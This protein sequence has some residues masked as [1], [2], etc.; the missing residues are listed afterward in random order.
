MF[1]LKKLTKCLTYKLQRTQLKEPKL[2]IQRHRSNGLL[3]STNTHYTFQKNFGRWKNIGP[4]VQRSGFQAPMVQVYLLPNPL[5]P[6]TFILATL[7]ILQVKTPAYPNVY[8]VHVSYYYYHDSLKASCYLTSESSHLLLPFSWPTL[9]LQFCL[10]RS[11]PAEELL[12]TYPVHTGTQYHKCT[13][14]F[15]CLSNQTVSCLRVKNMSYLCIPKMPAHGKETKAT[16]RKNKRMCASTKANDLWSG[17][18]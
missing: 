5:F 1:C 7:N 6:C 16:C 12:P 10:P 17:G 4:G 11:P 3:T 15:V 9:K 2:Q 14:L 13:H 8:S 18:H